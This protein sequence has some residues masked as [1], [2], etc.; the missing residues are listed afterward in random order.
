MMMSMMMPMTTRIYIK[1]LF[2]LD[3]NGILCHRIR[4]NNLNN[5]PGDGG[6]DERRTPSPPWSAY[7]PT[8]GPRIATTPVVPRPHLDSFLE[9]L[10][11]HFCLAVWTSGKAK[12]ARALVRALVPQ[13]IADRLLFVWAQHH[14]QVVEPPS[15]SSSPLHPSQVVYKKDLSRVWQEFP[16]W[17]HSNTLLLDDSPDKCVAWRENALHPPR[18]HGLRWRCGVEKEEE[19]PWSSSSSSSGGAAEI[20]TMSDEDNVAQQQI[21]LEQLVQHWREH[22]VTQ[23][24]DCEAQDAVWQQQPG[25][26]DNIDGGLL[27][28]FLRRHAV[29]HMGWNSSANC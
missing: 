19:E 11:R 24:W 8:T 21:F 15:S 26:T 10:D 16:L 17:N 7:R 27:Q 9:F 6:P 1:P 14:C 2:V 18:L 20:R 4:R 22:P 23:E 28:Q 13:P 25:G 5:L 3:L 29:G 12:T